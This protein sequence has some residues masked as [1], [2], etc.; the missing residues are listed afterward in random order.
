MC[1]VL[2]FAVPAAGQSDKL[3]VSV[4]VGPISPVIE[5]GDV[6]FSVVLSRALAEGESLDVPLRFGK[7]QSSPHGS[8]SRSDL[9]TLSIVGDAAGV[10]LHDDVR[11][12]DPDMDSGAVVSRRLVRFVGGDGAASR[13]EL[14][15]PIVDDA[16]VEPRVILGVGIDTLALNSVGKAVSRYW[17]FEVWIDDDDAMWIATKTSGVATSVEQ[18]RAAETDIHFT[19]YYTNGNRHTNKYSAG[20]I[21][22]L[23]NGGQ[24]ACGVPGGPVQVAQ[25]LHRVHS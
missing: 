8:V 17:E 6:V 24:H 22:S 13:V 1:A 19:I 11:V 4:E 23:Q 2:L 14:S 3:L 7:S 21:K 20:Q 10:S 25:R 12:S 5:G 9:G 18:N 16:V 15:L